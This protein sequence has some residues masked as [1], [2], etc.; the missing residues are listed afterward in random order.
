MDLP[1]R[2]LATAPDG[3]VVT[4]DGASGAPGLELSHWPGNRTPEHLR[5]RLSTGIALRFAMLPPAEREQLA[6]GCTAVVNNHY[7]T[8]GLCAAW[9]VLNPERARAQAAR[10]VAAAAAGDFM[11]VPDE[12]AF[13]ID[14]LIQAVADP[15]R[16]PLPAK[17]RDA[18]APARHQAASDYVL[19]HLGDWLAADLGDAALAEHADR[20]GPPLERL[21]ADFALL[22][23]E[24]TARRDL[25]DI[26]LVAF[27]LPFGTPADALPG[28]HALFERGGRDRILVSARQ[29]GD[30]SLL[31]LV[32]GTRSWFD[33]DPAE[34]PPPRFDLD[35][36]A[37]RLTEL[38]PGDDSIHWR[39]EGS[40]HASPELWF[41]TEEHT[42]YAEHHAGLRPTRL[43]AAAVLAAIDAAGD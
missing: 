32:V 15:G 40:Q 33:L 25:D 37:G 6:E 13:C 8:D 43:D 19:E 31:R 35:A 36:V 24:R 39:S 2:L 20:W 29:R 41:G 42:A 34:A 4:V 30:T 5:H 27:E 18:D 28:R 22:D 14:A 10:L 21:R 3:P 11:R 12:H 26:D 23:D 7:D 1:Y 17:L 9:A 38:E 16:S